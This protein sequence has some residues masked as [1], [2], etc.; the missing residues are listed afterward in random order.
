MACCNLLSVT[1]RLPRVA[2][3]SG[4]AKPRVFLVDDHRP[5]L[6]RVSSLL[7]DD[8]DVVGAFTESRQAVDAAAATSPDVVVLDIN[9]PGLDGFQ[10]MRAL[11]QAGSRA[12]FVI[13]S[14]LNG[15]EYVAEAF[16]AAHE[17]MSSSGS[18]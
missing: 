4:T 9:M 2:R 12:P 11:E 17:A 1:H 5:L 3:P 15:D 13:L 6:E 10:T 16:R 8:F 14:L 18:W 7:S